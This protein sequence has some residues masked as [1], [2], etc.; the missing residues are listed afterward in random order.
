MVQAGHIDGAVH[1]NEPRT[2]R[3][4]A[5]VTVAALGVVLIVA[6]TFATPLASGGFLLPDITYTDLGALLTRMDATGLDGMADTM[7]YASAYFS[8]AWVLGVVLV[9]VLG[10]GATW[11]TGHGAR[12]AARGFAFL[13][14]LGAIGALLAA[15][16]ELKNIVTM[17]PSIGVPIAG[18]GLVAIAALIGPGRV[19][20]A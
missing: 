14:A 12:S 18:Y 7:P 19:R 3:S 6:G 2:R 8:Y 13:A 17:A 20:R 4:P 16:M 5:G 15:M 9:S 1:F 11:P 10:L